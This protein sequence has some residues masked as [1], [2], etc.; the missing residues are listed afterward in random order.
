MLI[1][2]KLIWKVLKNH[3][4]ELKDI[5]IKTLF[6]KGHR[7]KFFS[8]EAVGITLD[9]S[10]QK[11]SLKTLNL[12]LELA[13]E[14][15]VSKAINK[16]MS[17][18][19]INVTEN[20]HVLHTA[21]RSNKKAYIELNGKNIIPQIHA[22][23]NKMSNIVNLLNYGKW[24][25]V[26]GKIITDVVNIGV[27]GSDLGPKMISMALRGF[28]SADICNINVHFAST[29][30]GTQ[31]F[32]ILPNLN[33]DTTL[34]IYSSKSFTTIDT[35][36]N[37]DTAL[38]WLKNNL[39]KP[40][41]IIKKHHFIGVSTNTD[42]MTKWGLNKEN[43][44][45]FLDEVGGRYSLWGAIGLIIAIRIGMKNFLRLLSGA[46]N[47][48]EHFRSASLE[49]NLPVILALIGIWNINFLNIPSHVVL[50][51]DGHLKFLP[52]YLQ[53]LEMESN[54]KSITN[55]SQLVDYFTCPIIWG[56]VGPNGQHAF[57]QLLHQGTQ[58]VSCD[59]IV[60]INPYHEIKPEYLRDRLNMQ[61]LLVLANCFAQ[62]RIL[63]LGNNDNSHKHYFGNKPSSTILLN[64]ISPEIIGSLIALYEHKV[65]VQG[66]I[67]GINSFDQWGVELGKKIANE[68]Y[69]IMTSGHGADILDDSSSNLIKY[70]WNNIKN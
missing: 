54:G 40:E 39:N 24:K 42:K 45:E 8:R 1:N 47:M 12:L 59:F 44:L 60:S 64:T 48:D 55:D 37:A 7:F 35:Q 43:Q 31:L 2:K 29:I 28:M 57:Y 49:N 33:P 67:W 14:A 10:K 4:N 18:N 66:I 58:S 50:P 5:H 3:F 52:S 19:Y 11:I 9:F 23:L 27:G 13:K 25:G 69:S 36:I 17:G 22:S 16:L 15:E 56:E 46:S 20:R 68:T 70:V 41:D 65:F 30:D 63:M 38:I 34:F 62:S 26:N 53:Q 21:L 51:Y 32:D 6:N 61:H